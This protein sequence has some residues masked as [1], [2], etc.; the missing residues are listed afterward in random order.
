MTVI[1]CTCLYKVS[2]TL[3]N[4]TCVCRGLWTCLLLRHSQK[5]LIL[6]FIKLVIGSSS[7]IVLVIKIRVKTK[8]S[9]T[10][11]NSLRLILALYQWILTL[12]NSIRRLLVITRNPLVIPTTNPSRNSEH[13]S[14]SQRP[15]PAIVVARL[16]TCRGTVMSS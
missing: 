2:S 4:C 8:C 13:R 6:L 3:C 7:S 9:N 12:L 10:R 14:P 16:A 1:N 15:S 5:Q 11:S